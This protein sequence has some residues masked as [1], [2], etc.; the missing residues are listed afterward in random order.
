MLLRGISN[1][2]QP[3]YTYQTWLHDLGLFI[4]LHNIL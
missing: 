1:V 3:N 4:I 2:N